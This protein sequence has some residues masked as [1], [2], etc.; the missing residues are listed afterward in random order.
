MK[1]ISRISK[2]KEYVI[3]RIRGNSEQ[4]VDNHLRI[5]KAK[6]VT[7]DEKKHKGTTK[8]GIVFNKDEVIRMMEI[9][10]VN[11]DQLNC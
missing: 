9:K 11:M 1:R 3:R 4:L 10:Q 7:Y 5:E 8:Y 6:E 2:T